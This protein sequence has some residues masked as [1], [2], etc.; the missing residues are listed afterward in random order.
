[1]SERALFSPSARGQRGENK[2]KVERANWF[3]PPTRPRRRHALSRPTY[4]VTRETRRDG[5]ETNSFEG[6]ESLSSR[7]VPPTVESNINA[8]I[9]VSFPP[10]TGS[11]FSR[12][13]Y[14]AFMPRVV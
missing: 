10:Y 2:E 7:S 9:A 11:A 4:D 6:M 13:G 1:M 5:E 8:C 14:I 3:S 12:V